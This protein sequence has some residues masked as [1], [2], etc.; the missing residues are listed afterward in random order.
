MSPHT[1]LGQPL[2]SADL[3]LI[4]T[5]YRTVHR[6]WVMFFLLAIFCF[7]VVLLLVFPLF[8]VG[9]QNLGRDRYVLA[10]S[11]IISGYLLYISLRYSRFFGEHRRLLKRDMNTGRKSVMAGEM[12]EAYGNAT[13]LH[14]KVNGQVVD[15]VHQ[16]FVSNIAVLQRFSTLASGRVEIHWLPHSRILLAAHYPDVTDNITEERAL[17]PEETARFRQISQKDV[18]T[19][20]CITRGVVTEL[21]EYRSLII[22]FSSSL[23]IRLKDEGFP[24]SGRYVL[25]EEAVVVEFI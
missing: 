9:W 5:L 10:F 13:G 16:F 23:F 8:L 12:G 7:M 24:I 20:C 15:V 25:G 14:Y 4:R 11:S 19:W 3:Q 21:L 1:P 6:N 22:P 2:S 18:P 17:T